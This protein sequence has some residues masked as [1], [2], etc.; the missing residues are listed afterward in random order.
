MTDLQLGGIHHL[1]AITADAPGNRRFYTDTLGMRLVKKTV[2]QDDISAYHLFYADGLAS[3]GTDLTFFDWPV[4]RERRG[5]HSDRAH[6]PPGG[7]RGEPRLVA[8]PA[9]RA[10]RRRRASSPRRDGRADA[11]LRGSRGPALPPGRRRRRRR[12]APVGRRAR[13]RPSTRSAASARSRSAC[14]GSSRP[15]RSSP[16]VHEHARGPRPTPRPTA[17]RTVHVY[18]M[19]AGGP[20]AELHVA[21]Q[22]GLPVARAG[23]G[24]RAPRRLPHARRRDRCTP[25]PS[26]CSSSG[27]PT[28]GEVDRYY[29]RSLYFREPERHPVRDR[30]RRPRLRRR[31]AAGDARRAAGAA[32]VPGGPAGRDRGA[33]S[34]RSTDACACPAPRFWQSGVMGGPRS[35]RA[36]GM[37][38][39]P[40][41][42][43]RPRG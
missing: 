14:R 35:R 22:P 23:R 20:A 26:A 30:H 32:A 27:V 17:R 42:A 36:G 37:R 11:R 6:R 4:P 25:G 33:V 28:S 34:C 18:E 43:P 3:P 31:R 39:A 9:R 24:R 19:G 21:V 29:F 13:C 16:S 1:T 10:R 12:R 7:R 8:R 41:A 2:N 40:G 15:T 38:T 5:T